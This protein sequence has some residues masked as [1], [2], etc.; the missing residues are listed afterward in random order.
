MAKGSRRIA[1]PE[2]ASRSESIMKVLLGLRRRPSAFEVCFCN[3]LLTS[4]SQRTRRRQDYW[5]PMLMMSSLDPGCSIFTD[6][7]KLSW[8]CPLPIAAG[9][10][11]IRG[12]CDQDQ[13]LY[14]SFDQRRL[15][16]KSRIRVPMSTESP[17]S[18]VPSVESRYWRSISRLCRQSTTGP[19]DPLRFRS[20][21]ENFN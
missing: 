5:L 3:S 21:A 12:P 19:A 15:T 10:S 13:G 4:L 6:R 14:R 18:G 8:S 1:D 7:I 9:K 2:S 11:F 20:L 16:V 17:I